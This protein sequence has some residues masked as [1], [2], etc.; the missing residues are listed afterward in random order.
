MCEPIS[1]TNNSNLDLK[2]EIFLDATE[3]KNP[4]ICQNIIEDNPDGDD[5]YNFFPHNSRQVLPSSILHRRASIWSYVKEFVGK[6]LTRITLPIF[7]NEPLSLLHKTAECY[8]LG[9]IKKVFNQNIS[10]VDRLEILAAN[11]AV[12]QS[13]HSYRT[14]KPFNPLLGETFEMRRDEKKLLFVSEQVCHHPPITAFYSQMPGFKGYGCYQLGISFYGNS[15]DTVV[16][17]TFTYE[18][19]DSHGNLQSL[20]SVVPPVNTSRNIIFGKFTGIF[21]SFL[22]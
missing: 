12:T 5:D 10:P 13:S 11:F 22:S 21:V 8:S 18:F 7:L 3:N 15:I 1:S 20:I 9:G 17:G 6:D 14:Y 2:E 16:D 19:Y 4:Q